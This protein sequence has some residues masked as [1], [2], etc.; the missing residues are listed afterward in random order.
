[1]Q[2]LPLAAMLIVCLVPTFGQSQPSGLPDEKVFRYFFLHV[3]AA[4]SVADTLRAKGKDDRFARTA[5]RSEANL[6]NREIEIVKA[7]AQR[8]NADYGAETALGMAEVGDLRR[9]YPPPSQG[10]SQPPPQ[11]AQRINALDQRRDAV[12]AGCI[13]NLKAQM[14]ERRF[15]A[16]HDWVLRAEGPKIKQVVAGKR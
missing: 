1:M 3:T 16:L 8:C 13:Q 14:G 11:V 6:T 4:D 10:S 7:T 9:Q 2:R 5:I 12:I 15:R